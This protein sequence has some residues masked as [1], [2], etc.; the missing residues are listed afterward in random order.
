MNIFGKFL[1]FNE[2]LICV[3]AIKKTKWSFYFIFFLIFPVI[4]FLLYPMSILGRRGFF[5][6]LS[7]IILFSFIAWRLFDQRENVYLLTNRRLLFLEKNNLSHN[8][9]GSV[10]LSKIKKIKKIGS[11]G[12]ALWI[13]QKRFDLIKLEN[14]DLIYQKIIKIKSS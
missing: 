6:W 5:L 7:I 13:K 14:R 12:I 10:P 3:S 4:F 2:S 1:E 9:R 8:L 11:S